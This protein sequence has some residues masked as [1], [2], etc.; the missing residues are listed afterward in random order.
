MRRAHRTASTGRRRAGT[1]PLRHVARHSA[2]IHI[3]ASR[4][5]RG[6]RRADTQHRKYDDEG[7]RL[8][9][10]KGVGRYPDTTRKMLPTAGVLRP[11]YHAPLY[12][13]K[14][15]REYYAVT[16]DQF[17]DQYVN[18]LREAYELDTGGRRGIYVKLRSTKDGW[19]PNVES[20][21]VWA[22]TKDARRLA[23]RLRVLHYFFPARGRRVGLLVV[24]SDT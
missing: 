16:K 21:V 6:I 15:G 18:G 10:E 23:T 3:A 2:R 4:P 17:P 7:K 5:A 22:V 13:D 11:P 24:A 1:Q 12:E 9:S 14:D 20:G 19:P 8:E